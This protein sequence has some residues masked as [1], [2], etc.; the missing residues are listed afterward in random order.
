M[1]TL[2]LYIVGLVGL[3]SYPFGSGRLSKAQGLD[4]YLVRTGDGM[5]RHF[6][7]LRIT[8]QRDI[9]LENYVV[10]V[11]CQGAK[12]ENGPG[13]KIRPDDPSMPWSSKHWVSELPDIKGATVSDK[14]DG[15]VSA[16]L[17]LIDGTLE[18]APPTTRLYQSVIWQ[19]GGHRQ[20]FTDRVQYTLRCPGNAVVFE[21]FGFNGAP[22]RDP[23]SVNGAD[24]NI[25]ALV[26]NLPESSERPLL[27][28]RGT[29]MP[30][31]AAA[32]R[33]LD[34][35][36]SSQEEEQMVPHVETL[37]RTD[38]N[39]EDPAH[40]IPFFLRAK[41]MGVAMRKCPDKIVNC[42]KPLT[43]AR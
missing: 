1:V 39:G 35:Q 3:L 16:G 26:S 23:L 22:A 40:C 19:M 33:L 37:A 30:H 4:A 12:P 14:W 34:R 28:K 31:F 11:H 10:T 17:K 42:G 43:N 36:P 21:F 5:A 32:Y 24:G 38:G 8:G 25:S 7:R 41:V 15:S 27:L 20:A 6:A 9:P 13:V 29:P 18:A 2:T